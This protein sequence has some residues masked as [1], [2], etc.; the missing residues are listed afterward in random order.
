MEM[1][2]AFCMQ[3]GKLPLRFH[4]ELLDGV[5]FLT[6]ETLFDNIS[7][8]SGSTTFD[9]R[10]PRELKVAQVAFKSRYCH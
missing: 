6:Y 2:S 1:S 7:F 10:Y 8:G 3:F 4:E 9:A 5:D